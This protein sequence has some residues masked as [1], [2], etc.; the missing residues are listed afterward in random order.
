MRVNNHKQRVN[1]CVVPTP[2]YFLL[3]LTKGSIL[4]TNFGINYVI[5]GFN[6]LDLTMNTC[7]STITCKVLLNQPHSKLGQ[8]CAVRCSILTRHNIRRHT[9][10][11]H[12]F[13]PFFMLPTITLAIVK[14]DQ[15]S[16][17]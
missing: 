2:H 3:V 1:C 10:L 6:K 8:N 14:I 12:F 4:L 5:N 15:K 9:C 7:Y 13:H 11:I 17:I 16:N